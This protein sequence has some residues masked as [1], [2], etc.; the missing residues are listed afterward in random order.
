MS[1]S[2]PRAASGLPVTLTRKALARS[3]R[4]TGYH[5]LALAIGAILAWLVLP[6]LVVLAVT[7]F[8]QV[9]G[10]RSGPLTLANY[11]ALTSG[12]QGGTIVANSLVF[13]L[14]S[15]VVAV[16]LGTGLAWLAERT[17][18]YFRRTA[19][20]AAFI[21]LSIPLIVRVLGWILL[22]GPENGLL[23]VA[24]RSLFGTGV[25]NI[26][27]MAGMIAV[28]GLTWVPGAFLLLG[29]PLRAMDPSLEESAFAHGAN[30]WQTTRRVVLPLI[31]PTL[32][33]VFLLACINALENFEIAAMV[34]MP[35]HIFVLTSE[36][37]LE[38]STSVSPSYGQASA[39]AVVLMLVVLL[40]FI[41]YYRATRNAQRFATVTGKGFRVRKVDLGRWR[42]PAGLCLLVLPLLIVLPLVPLLWASGAPYYD[43]PTLGAIGT[44]GLQN[45]VAVTRDDTALRSIWNSVIVSGASATVV[46][47]LSLV[48]AWFVVRARVRGAVRLDQL[49]TL[50]L[51]IPAIVLGIALVRTYLV[52]PIPIYG[53]LVILI[54][55]FVT[56]F[57]PYGVRYSSAGLFSLHRELEDSAQ[58]SGASWRQTLQRVVIP[59]VMPALSAGWVFVFLVSFRDLGIPVLLYSSG[60][61]MVATTILDL[62][63]NAQLPEVAAFSVMLSVGL[64]AIASLMFRVSGRYGRTI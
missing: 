61:E 59:L 10:N 63:D 8:T 64:V 40:A 39:F 31:A 25:L 52:V 1:L 56:H 17:N 15:A 55:A 46:M 36:I 3:P 13:A 18:A 5:W 38:I 48:V 60:T 30:L 34:G 43:V 33:A 22:L 47:L 26:Y 9:R 21:S 14:G 53:T 49:A 41:P 12:S 29:P 19:F 44:L 4:L 27:T 42:L 11:Q 2:V 54:I 51:M 23:N 28:Q 57:L 6:P 24:A 62:W 20:L 37:Y 16:V 45:Y 32:A 50:P 58:M 7:S 35:A